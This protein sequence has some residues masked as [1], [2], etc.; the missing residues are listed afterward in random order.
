MLILLLSE[1]SLFFEKDGYIKDQV[2]VFGFKYSKI[3]FTLLNKVLAIYIDFFLY[4]S[5]ALVL[6]TLFQGRL[7]DFLKAARVPD[8]KTVL[9]ICCNLS[10]M[11]FCIN[12]KAGKS[13]GANG[14]SGAE[15]FFS[16]LRL[17]RVKEVVLE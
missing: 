16:F 9:T 7:K 4:I 5:V 3:V 8:S 11:Y 6:K 12:E 17:L 13:S 14:L 15:G 2:K 1:Y 10:S